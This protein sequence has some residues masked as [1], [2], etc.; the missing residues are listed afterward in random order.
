MLLLYV[1]YHTCVR[2]T[3]ERTT[4]A[5]RRVK[6]TPLRLICQ[7]PEKEAERQLVGTDVYTAAALLLAKTTTMAVL[8]YGVSRGRNGEHQLNF[9]RI[10]GE[11]G[12]GA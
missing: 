3:Q 10:R 12:G 1:S 7:L 2:D 5:V 9:C 11:E 4:T 6:C 8:L